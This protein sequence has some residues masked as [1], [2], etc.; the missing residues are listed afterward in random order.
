MRS[1][2]P[3]LPHPGA[4]ID[5]AEK[6]GAVHLLG[7]TTR[8]LTAEAISREPGPATYFVNVHPADL[9]D[10]DLY[11]RAA[12]L[13]KHA[14]RVVIEITERSTLEGVGDLGRRVGELRA[15]GFRVAV[16]DLGA[17]YAG[18]S[19]FASLQ[20]DVVK[21]DMSLVRNPRRASEAARGPVDG[22]PLPR[23]RDRVVGEGVE[24]VAER[25]TLVRLGC[26]HLQGFLFGRPAPPFPTAR[27]DP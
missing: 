5:A 3:S 25:D 2:E 11:D 1:R 18:L 14:R 12:P 22:D 8:A 17:G 15:L 27:W 9:A 10:A 7:R 16:D 4:V 13:T 21:I 23:A 24:T 20:P 26:T 19:Y 6:L